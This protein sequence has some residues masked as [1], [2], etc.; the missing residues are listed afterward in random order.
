MAEERIATRLYCD[1]TLEPGASVALERSEAH[2]L[3]NV[4]RLQPGDLLLDVACGSGGPSLRIARQVGC[5]VHG[6]D[7][8]EHGIAEAL[9]Q[10]AAAGASRSAHRYPVH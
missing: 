2:L 4:L 1:R 10:A 3:R 5:R 7:L 8:H 9:A 6:V